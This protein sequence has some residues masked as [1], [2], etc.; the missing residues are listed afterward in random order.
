MSAIPEG[1]ITM[2]IPWEAMEIGRTYDIDAWGI[3]GRHTIMIDGKYWMRDGVKE[4]D[5]LLNRIKKRLN[6][7]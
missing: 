7:R 4:S 6:W 5:R 2:P 1:Y 3:N